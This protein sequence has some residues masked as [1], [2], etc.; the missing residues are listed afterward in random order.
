MDAVTAGRIDGPQKSPR[1][2]KRIGVSAYRRIGVSASWE[3]KLLFDVPIYMTA[4][5]RQDAYA[6][7]SRAKVE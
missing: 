1:W 2:E 6:T 4:R 7:L 5:R 3:A